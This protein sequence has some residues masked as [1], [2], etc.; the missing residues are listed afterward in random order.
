MRTQ[1]TA[2]AVACLAVAVAGAATA[3]TSRQ[4]APIPATFVGDSISA[5]ITY[6]PAARKRLGRGLAVK[7]DVAVCRRLVQPSCSFQGSTPTTALQA[8][9]A[10]GASL[11]R[12]LIVSV[13][14]NEGPQGYASGIDRVVRT[15]LAEGAVGVVWV[16]LREQGRYGSLYHATNLAIKRAPK[17]WPQLHVADWNAH[18]R[19]KPWFGEDGLH[20]SP[21]G[22]TELASFIRPYVFRASSGR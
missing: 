17:R 2:L 20:L 3:A 5:S 1:L 14:Y 6:V 11:G 7:L 15:A 19:G 16:T 9:Q 8:V 12:V 22:A 21:R 4:D 13:G 18:S 10:Q